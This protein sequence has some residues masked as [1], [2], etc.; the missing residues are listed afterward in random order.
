MDLTSSSPA[1]EHLYLRDADPWLHVVD[2]GGAGPPI[3]LLHGL[4][5]RATG[6]GATA[7]HLRRHFRPIALDLRGHGE[8][9]KP[10]SG[11][12]LETFSHDVL[13]VLDALHLERAH[14]TA[15][16]WAGGSR[17]ASQ[18]HFRARWTA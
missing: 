10:S 6:W 12:D 5:G 3:L 11:Y 4:S 8:S 9:G 15:T 16:R 7:L 18:R 2:W 14:L 1:P 17:S 13:R